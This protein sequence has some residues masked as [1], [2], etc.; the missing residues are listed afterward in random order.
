MKSAHIEPFFATLK[1]A[2]VEVV[3]RENT[4]KA[5]IA[6]IIKGAEYANELGLAQIDVERLREFMLSVMARMR[7]EVQESPTDLG[8][9]MSVSTVLAEFL[10]STRSRNTLIT[11]RIWVARGKPPKG[12]VNIIGDVSKLGEISVQIGRDDGLIRISS[13]FFSRWMAE[14]N[15]S[16]STFMKRM[17]EEF[18]MTKVNGKLAGGTEMSCAMEHLIELDMNHPKLSKFLG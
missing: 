9:D 13:T 3:G 8:N 1:A 6:V 16:R 5:M 15:Y 7:G 2:N 14:R 17:Q 4:G 12:Q 10:N 11:N 18:G